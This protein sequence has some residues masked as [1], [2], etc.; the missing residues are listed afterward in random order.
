MGRDCK[1]I[2]DYIA[3]IRIIDCNGDFHVYSKDEIDQEKF[4]AIQGSFGLF[5]IIWDIT[6]DVPPLMIVRTVN[7]YETVEKVMQENYLKDLLDNNWSVE[8]FWFPFNSM[9]TPETLEAIFE[10]DVDCDEWDPMKDKMWIRK[11]NPEENAGEIK[12]RKYYKWQSFTDWLQMVGYNT[13][14][15]ILG[16]GERPNLT[17]WFLKNQYDLIEDYYSADEMISQQLPYAIHYREHIPEIKCLDLEFAIDVGKDYQNIK[18]ATL[19]MRIY[20]S[21]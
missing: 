8:L 15:A 20:H 4:Q 6:F 9:T 2:N 3:K 19:V 14:D 18:K 21:L 13:G 16:F 17:P 10:G 12:G 11:I 5:G 7:A 1:T